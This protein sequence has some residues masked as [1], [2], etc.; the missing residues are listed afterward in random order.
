[1]K[2]FGTVFT[3]FFNDLEN[4]EDIDMNRNKLNSSNLAN[5][6]ALKIVE[7]RLSKLRLLLI[8]LRQIC[9]AIYDQEHKKEWRDIME[10]I[11][12]VLCRGENSKYSSDESGS[13]L[14]NLIRKM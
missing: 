7:K 14:R 11:D 9:C 6:D 2:L 8:R 13:S 4:L 10:D 3:A 1:M 12:S 5:D